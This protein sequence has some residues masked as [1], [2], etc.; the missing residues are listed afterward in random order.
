VVGYSYDPADRV[1]AACVGAAG[2]TGTATG[3]TAYTYDLA[4][5]RLTQTLS[6]SAGNATTSYRY[7][8]ADEL[9]MATLAGGATTSYTYDGSGNLSQAGA[10]R[11]TYNLDRTLTAATVGGT[12]THYTYDAQ[13]I[14]LTAVVDGT[15]GPVTRT[16][17]FDVNGRSA[18]VSLEATSRAGS[19][20]SRGFLIGPDNVP[21]GLADGGHVDAYVPDWLG[22]V[23]AVEA[24]DGSD[25]AAY[26]FDPYGGPRSDGTAAATPTT[27]D[28]P[29]RFAGAYADSTLGQRYSFPARPYDPS[30]GRFDGL[31]PVAA[32]R[33]EPIT[34]G[35]AYVND[36]PT[37]LTDPS[38]ACLILDDTR[39][40]IRLPRTEPS[41]VAPPIIP[42]PVIPLPRIVPV[43][44]EPVPPIV[45][46]AGR[47]GALLGI[48]ACLL[49]CLSGDSAPDTTRVRIDTDER[50]RGCLDDD[51]PP[52]EPSYFTLIDGRASGVEACLGPWS[53]QVDD[54][55]PPTPRGFQAGMNRSH[56]L[57]R[58]LG[59]H[60]ILENIVPLWEWA[61]KSQMATVEIRVR[62]LAATQAV[63]YAAFPEYPLHSSPR[64]SEL[65][66][67]PVGVNIYYA[68][69]G[70][71]H[72]FFVTNAK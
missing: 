6:G 43:P 38:G 64:F 53:K 37:V 31:D 3:R 47:T 62:G 19:T 13:G 50:K 8:S 51:S 10:D 34:N 24:P 59:G 65:G 30:T 44:P 52:Q 33:T 23:S 55:P 42:P 20:S 72:D 1:L 49:F 17:S 2:C 66:E 4:G 56:L 36:R 5:N 25:L 48:L 28:N 7:D 11:F 69:K 16:S 12:T 63:Y 26:D 67:A 61:N 14:A 18:V 71:V 9:T 27:V 68:T 39:H 32:K 40:C 60:S 29:L 58:A 54:R 21:L 45:R 22:G 70:E 41:L 35:Y 15:G 46:T 57:M